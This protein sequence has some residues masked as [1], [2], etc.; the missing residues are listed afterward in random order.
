MYPTLIEW[1]IP[2]STFGVMMALGFLLAGGMLA[3]AFAE[4]GWPRDDAWT[5]VFWCAVGGVLG[6]KLW[7]VAEQLARGEVGDITGF[8]FSRGG[9]TWYGGLLG[10]TLAG[11]LTTSRA[12]RSILDTAN[13]V[14]APLAAGQAVGR[15][16]CFLVGDDYGRPTDA[17]FGIAFPRG[18]PPTDQPVHPTQLYEA[19]WLALAAGWLHARRNSSPSPFAEYLLIAGAGRLVIETVRLNP[20]ALGPLTNAQLVAI[21]CMVAGAAG[22][23]VLRG[24]LRPSITQRA[25]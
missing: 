5:F 4:R 8:L 2:I 17:W 18:L 19:F 9:I 22:W 13:A 24:R 14:A 12:R 6:A 20:L 7:Y 16:G 3:R 1:P 10:G 11:L 15:L 25:S 23:L 21:A